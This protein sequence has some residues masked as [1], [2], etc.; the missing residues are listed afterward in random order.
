[1][2]SIAVI[3]GYY[4]LAP[5]ATMLVSGEVKGVLSVEIIHDGHEVHSGG[6][7]SV[8]VVFFTCGAVDVCQAAELHGVAQAVDRPVGHDDLKVFFLFLAE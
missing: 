2:G 1:M 4:K 7:L 8:A 3:G 5:A 6:R